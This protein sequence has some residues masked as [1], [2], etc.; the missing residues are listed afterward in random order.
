MY[1]WKF[2]SKIFLCMKIIDDEIFIW[3]G[4][5]IGNNLYRYWAGQRKKWGKRGFTPGPPPTLPILLL[6]WA[7]W[8]AQ[9]HLSYLLAPHPALRDQLSQTDLSETSWVEKSKLSLQS[10]AVIAVSAIGKLPPVLS[11]WEN[12]KQKPFSSNEDISRRG[13]ASSYDDFC[14]CLFDA[15]VTWATFGYIDT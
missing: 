7:F 3:G 11:V 4:R 10:F 8:S 13:Y 9:Q 12:L 6:R 2:S 14:I 5:Y 1:V 15:A